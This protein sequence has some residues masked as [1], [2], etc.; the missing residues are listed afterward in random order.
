MKVSIETI[1]NTSDEILKKV[2][3]PEDDRNIIVNSIIYAHLA[4]KSTHGIGRLPIY[5]R[6]IKEGLMSAKTNLTVIKDT[7]V[8]SHFDAQNGFGQV[9]AFKG[10]KIAIE[11]AK[12][13]GT[14]VVG[15][16]GSNNFGTAGFFAE[17]AAKNNMI[18]I[19]CSNASPA[20]APTGGYKPIFGT[21]P[22][23]I[24]FPGGNNKPPVILDMAT[25]NAARGKIRLAA[26]NGEKIPDDWALDKNG[27]P[28]SDPLEALK[29]S[30]IPIG[31]YKGYGL[32]LAIDVLAGLL[33]CSSFGGDVKSLNH[34]DSLS[35]NGHLIIVI[36]IS[37]FQDVPTFI[38]KM[39]YLT[40]N[41]KACGDEQMI[42]LPGEKK[43]NF[44]L[45]SKGIGDVSDKQVENIN[46]L[47]KQLGLNCTIFS[48]L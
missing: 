3:V 24:G 35:R 36:N 29:G 47:T 20:I 16:K 9:A 44:Q 30:M 42:F 5:V 15:I 26:V 8:L 27:M 13:Y 43:Y 22:I 4:N 6:K 12:V 23:S 41:I 19:I 21:N 18:G 25:S 31:G 32:S 40:E 1:K 2:G 28:T 34:S 37:F 48:T 45:N 10:M 17:L 11:K 38:N 46:S 33:T 14:A 7:P 39:D